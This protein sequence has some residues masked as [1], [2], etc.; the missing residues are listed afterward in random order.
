MGERLPRHLGAG[1]VL[2]S[3]MSE[4][5]VDELLSDLGEI[6]M[7]SGILIPGLAR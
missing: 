5:E 2:A 3:G 4:S 7:Q 1:R 6:D